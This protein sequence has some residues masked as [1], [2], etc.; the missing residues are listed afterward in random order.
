MG[1]R[2]RERKGGLGRPSG[3]DENGG[4]AHSETGPGGLEAAGGGQAAH[5]EGRGGAGV[6]PPGL[7]LAEAR[8]SGEAE[9]CSGHT[10]LLPTPSKDGQE[11]CTCARGA[12]LH[13]LL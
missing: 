7:R 9:S 1:I 13:T 6:R 2:V 5:M 3:A 10:G 8:R 11:T 12:T 4:K